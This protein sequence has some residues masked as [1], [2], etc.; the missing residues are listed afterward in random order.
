MTII[1]SSGAIKRKLFQA[2]MSDRATADPGN[3]K[4][5]LNGGVLGVGAMPAIDF[6][7]RCSTSNSGLENAAQMQADIDLVNS[8]GGGRIILPR[9]EFDWDA[10]TTN[11]YEPS[12]A[13]PRLA[14]TLWRNKVILEGEGD[15]TIIKWADNA[16]IDGTRKDMF[17]FGSITS[18]GIRGV[19]F[20]GNTAGNATLFGG[21]D[22]YNTPGSDLALDP[23]L[24][25]AMVV[26]GASSNQGL[27][28]ICSDLFF[29][30]ISS[31]DHYWY[32][33][34]ITRGYR[35]RTERLRTT[36]AGCMF[37]AIYAH[38]CFSRDILR[39]VAVFVISN[40]EYVG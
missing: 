18:G 6:A 27:D 30:D 9:G 24:G 17:V 12:P 37:E 36:D 8:L 38:D 23:K 25:G 5:W 35:I 13:Y 15:E 29:D 3:N 33:L 19:R 28:A 32:F 31:Y 1:L 2:D 14:G 10:E 11:P 4:L 26:V 20:V 16:L 39:A 40:P 22:E 7:S 34:S 21:W